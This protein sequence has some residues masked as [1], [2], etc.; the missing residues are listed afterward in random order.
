LIVLA[1]LAEAKDQEQMKRNMS[2]L[3]IANGWFGRLA[4]SLKW[5]F[6]F[7]ELLDLSQIAQCIW[8]SARGASIT[9][10]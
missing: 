2:Y 1:D 4:L 6:G 7:T 5:D 10:P 3:L 8:K 9:F